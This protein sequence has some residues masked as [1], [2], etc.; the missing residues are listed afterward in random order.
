MEGRVDAAWAAARW[1]LWQIV[2]DGLK[3]FAT[4]VPHTGEG[5]CCLEAGRSECHFKMAG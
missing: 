4:F 5:L 3:G 2:V 1:T